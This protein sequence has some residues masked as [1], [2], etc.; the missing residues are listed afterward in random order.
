MKEIFKN[1]YK[2]MILVL[3]YIIVASTVYG[4]WFH[5][6]WN[7][8]YVTVLTIVLIVGLGVLIGYFYIKSLIKKNEN[9]IEKQE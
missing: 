1:Y 9:S 3:A 5:S 2:S 8:W 4:V 7:L 6:I